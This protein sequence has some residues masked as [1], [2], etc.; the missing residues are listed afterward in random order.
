MVLAAF[1]LASMQLELEL[2]LVRAVAV[3]VQSMALLFVRL[4][5]GL[6]H[7]MAQSMDNL[8][9]SAV[10]LATEL[11]VAEAEAGGEAVVVVQNSAIVYL[12]TDPVAAFA[13]AL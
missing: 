12:R 4:A 13:R 11:V 8:G 5:V 1:V 7:A 10:E 6:S 9:L 2:E 3:M